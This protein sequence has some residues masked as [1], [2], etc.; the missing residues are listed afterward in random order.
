M[1]K[2]L[3]FQSIQSHII[4]FSLI[5]STILQLYANP[6][7]KNMDTQCNGT[8]YLFVKVGIIEIDPSAVDLCAPLFSCLIQFLRRLPVS[9]RQLLSSLLPIT[10]S[11]MP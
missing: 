8:F 5:F 1:K 7:S 11:S 2:Y 3:L 6:C 4:S 10:M 9:V